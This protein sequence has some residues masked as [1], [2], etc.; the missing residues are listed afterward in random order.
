MLKYY[1]KKNIIQFTFVYK[2][3]TVRIKKELV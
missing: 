1:Y 3:L 2:V